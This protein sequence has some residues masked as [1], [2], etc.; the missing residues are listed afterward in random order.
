M[1]LVD[2]IS[3]PILIHILGKYKKNLV[4]RMEYLRK[5]ENK[6]RYHYLHTIHYEKQYGE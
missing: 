4:L 5:V 3:T 1:S 6:L 2:L